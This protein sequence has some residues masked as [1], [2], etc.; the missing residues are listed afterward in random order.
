SH[1]G[2]AESSGVIVWYSVVWR[3]LQVL[4]AK[5]SCRCEEGVRWHWAKLIHGRGH[6]Q[7]QADQGC[8][9]Q[10][11]STIMSRW[12]RRMAADCLRLP[13]ARRHVPPR[14]EPEG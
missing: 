5:I 7:C 11:L 14:W 3:V 13:L 10:L 4:W 12:A 2:I 9:E 8:I 6:R 1:Q